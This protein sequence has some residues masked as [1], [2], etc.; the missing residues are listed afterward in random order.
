MD[1]SQAAF[2]PSI[3]SAR[4]VECDRSRGSITR[5]SSLEP[6][7]LALHRTAPAALTLAFQELIDRLIAFGRV[8]SVGFVGQSSVG[9]LE[10]EL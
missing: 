3:A 10:H 9:S 4:N 7:G 2:R 6:G 1:R 8:L 5:A